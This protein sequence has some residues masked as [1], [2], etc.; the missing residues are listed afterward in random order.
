MIA[1]LLT[2]AAVFAA[3]D[4]LAQLEKKLHSPD[5][6][7]RRSAVQDLA[8]LDSKEALSHVLD[9]LADVSAQVADEAEVQLAKLVRSPEL[10]AE[11][12]GKRG[13]LAKDP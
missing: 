1:L 7:E 11:L 6:R 10:L 12:C 4:D 2:I 9:A 13:L 3:G 8:K 5:E